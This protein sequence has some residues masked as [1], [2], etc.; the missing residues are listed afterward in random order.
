MAPLAAGLMARGDP[1]AQLAIAYNIPPGIDPLPIVLRFSALD[2][3][4]IPQGAD[5]TM[6]LDGPDQ[7]WFLI[8]AIICIA[9]AGLFLI[10][11][12]YT[13]LAVV[14]SFELADCKHKSQV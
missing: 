3:K 12:I 5:R 1:A 10:V 4:A 8:C 6:T 9:A 7:N 13:K 14:R 11:R 2:P